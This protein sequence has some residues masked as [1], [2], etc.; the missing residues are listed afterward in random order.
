MVDYDKIGAR[1]REQ[2]KY[3]AK[4][5]QQKMAEDLGMYQADISNLEKAK[6]GS[7]ITDLSKLDSIAEYFDMPLQSLLFGVDRTAMPKYAGETM[8]LKQSKKKFNK[9]HRRILEKHLDHEF[10]DDYTPLTYEWG[11]YTLYV[12]TENMMIYRENPQISRLPKVHMY[13]FY[14]M[15]LTALLSAFVT[16]VMMH[17]YQPVFAEL[18]LFIQQDVLDHTDVLR[19]LNPYWM[20]YQLIS[21]E[22]EN[23]NEI[24]QSMLTRMDELRAKGEDRPILYL[25]GLYVKEENRQKGICRMCMDLLKQLYEG[26]I[27]WLNMSPLSDIELEG[28]GFTQPLYKASDVGQMNINAA[29]AERLGFTVDPDF[30]HLQTKII[31]SDGNESIGV[32]ECRKCAYFLPSEIRE[33]LAGDGRLVADGRALQRLMQQD[34]EEKKAVD[35]RVGRIEGMAAA[36]MKE[37]TKNGPRIGSSKCFTVLIDEENPADQRFMVT[38]QS[39]FEAGK[40]AEED[41]L[42]SYD[43]EE[44]ASQSQYAEELRFAYMMHPL[45]ADNGNI[46]NEL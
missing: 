43:S 45:A 15:E 33:L 2:R 23:Y 1:I 42:E 7:G 11:P 39:I 8:V 26:C 31:D 37:T 17:V 28:T 32:V 27:I 18:P 10:P 19:T 44:A 20:L 13:V 30:W 5:S 9:T 40:I 3:I 22:D 36:E 12:L 6:S 46:E 25:D 41:I 29:I 24:F 38:R 4:I 34:T 35:F 16:T 21:E 14:N